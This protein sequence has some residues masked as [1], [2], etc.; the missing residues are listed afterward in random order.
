MI[1]ILKFLKSKLKSNTIQKLVVAVSIL[2]LSLF[3]GNSVHDPFRIDSDQISHTET[4]FNSPLIPA[5]SE[6]QSEK[7]QLTAPEE[8]ILVSNSDLFKVPD[9]LKRKVEFWMQIYG[10]Y[11]SEYGVFHDAKEVDLIYS[12]VDFTQITRSNL[13][14]FTKEHRIHKKLEE[15]RNQVIRLL[16]QFD[17]GHLP[18]KMTSNEQRIWDYYK[19]KKGKHKFRD[20]LENLRFQLGQ[21]DFTEKAFYYSGIYLS[22]MERIFMKEKLPIELTRIPFVESSFNIMARSRVGASGIWQIMPSTGK[23]LIPNPYVDYRNDPLK[24]TEFAAKLLKFNYKVLKTWPLAITAYNHGATSLLKFK[25]QYDTD[26]LNEI[27][28]RAFGKKAFGFAS[29]NFYT[30]FLAILQ[31]EKNFKEYY[32]DLRRGNPLAVRSITLKKP[33]AFAKLLNIFDNNIK[34]LESYNPHITNVVKRSSKPIPKGT[35]LYFP[36]PVGEEV[37]AIS[38]DKILSL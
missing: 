25:K 11:T 13:H 19:S 3:I 10:K 7:G 4:T 23:K 30:C 36:Y 35:L 18:K 1:N 8:P 12:I 29:S 24:A 20:A 16:K 33:L 31:I 37:A 28:S 27:I 2:F 21:K 22:E 34:L 38:S 9:E 5:E 6:I 32:P 17:R 26:D 14:P 15:E